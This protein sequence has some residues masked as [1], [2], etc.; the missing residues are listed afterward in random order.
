MIRAAAAHLPDGPHRAP[1]Q[2]IPPDRCALSA[3]KGGVA[4]SFT[5]SELATVTASNAAR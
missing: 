4:R 1:A 2:P 5:G 3:V